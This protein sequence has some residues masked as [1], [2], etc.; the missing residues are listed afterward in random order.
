MVLVAVAGCAT[1][2]VTA[3]E[4]EI[5]DERIAKPDHI[6]VYDFAATAADVPAD[7]GASTELS[8]PSAPPSAKEIEAGRKLGE[9][10][11]GS[12]ASKITA[13]GLSAVHAG[14]LSKPKVGDMMIHGQFGSIEEGSAGKRLVLGF[15]S[16]NAELN[17]LV[18]AYQVTANGRRKLGSGAIDSE[19]GKS[20]GLLV[21]LAVTVATANPIGLVVVGAAKAGSEISGRNSIETSAE[22]TATQIAAELERAFQKQGWI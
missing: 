20:P 16:G 5:G 2:K 10:V 11:A 9:L 1:S 19:G 3:R 18:Q 22:R 21:P 6:Y 7:V 14:P 15:G 13:M 17:T 12:L 4:S 8:E